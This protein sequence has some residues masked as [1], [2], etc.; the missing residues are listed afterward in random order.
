MKAFARDAKAQGLEDNADEEEES[1]QKH[2][3]SFY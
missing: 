1:S 2:T 3:G